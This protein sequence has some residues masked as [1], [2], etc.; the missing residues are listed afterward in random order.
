MRLVEEQRFRRLLRWYPR[1]WRQE[2]GAVLLST[3]LDSAE[4]EGRTYPSVAERVGAVIHGGAAHIDRRVALLLSVVA[5]A[6]AILAGVVAVWGFV[7]GTWLLPSLLTG[8]V[9]ALSALGLIAVLREWGLIGD[10]RTLA[11][12]ATSVVALSLNALTYASWSLGF[13]AADEGI[14]LTGLAA[15]WLPLFAAA[16]LAGAIAV[17]IVV[18]ALLHRTSLHS[19]V[20]VVLAGIVG[21]VAAPLI[22]FSLISPIVSALVAL[23]TAVLATLPHRHAPAAG[24]SL[25]PAEASATS[26]PER[27]PTSEPALKSRS[28][29]RML[30]WISAGASVVGGVYAFTGALWAPAAVDST[31]AMGQGITI[32]FASGLPL[33]SSLGLLLAAAPSRIRSVHTWASLIL[34]AIALGVVA[35]GYLYAPSWNAMAPWFQ[36]GSVLM[37]GAIS[38]WIISRLRLPRFAALLIGVSAGALYSSFVG[39]MLLPMLAFIVPIG[40]FIVALHRPKGTQ[41]RPLVNTDAALAL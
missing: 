16:V 24:S 14:T 39:T 21:I 31:M 11:A 13:D 29:A 23:T 38:W 4:R 9:P 17:A 1:R 26:G 3:L 22:G 32:L 28:T 40:A 37:G 41:L 33:L 30:A 5:V 35:V 12:M 15:L 36:T 19:L 6:C 8:I 25:G 10:G 34:V 27:R 20:R 18:E 7:G 2:N